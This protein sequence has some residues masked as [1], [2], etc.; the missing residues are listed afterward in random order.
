[1]TVAQYAYTNNLTGTTQSALTASAGSQSLTAPSGFA[2]A[3]NAAI[4][5]G[6]VMLFTLATPTQGTESQWEIVACTA[7]VTG[8]GSDTLTIQRAFESTP[9]CPGD[10]TGTLP[11]LAWS[12]GAK[13][14]ARITSGIYGGLV[15]AWMAARKSSSSG[16]PAGA[17]VGEWVIIGGIL[18]QVQP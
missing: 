10:Q 5:A 2:A 6:Q 9:T 12:A 17:V 8:S 4:A 1:M 18:C 3:F 16:I 7:A 15:D 13:I 14:E 11:G